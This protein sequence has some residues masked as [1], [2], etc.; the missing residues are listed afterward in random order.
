VKI[1]V[2]LPDEDVQFLDAR[3]AGRNRSAVLHEA[4]QLLRQNYLSELY[5]EAFADWSAGPDAA[6]W[7]NASADGIGA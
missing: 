6:L 4:V 3:G 5:A 2:S 1:S 7:E